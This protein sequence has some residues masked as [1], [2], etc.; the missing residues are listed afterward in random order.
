M[1]DTQDT[2]TP[3]TAEGTGAAPG[4]G[5]SGG[6]S[7]QGSTTGT[8]LSTIPTT[9]TLPPQYSTGD[10]GFFTR[11][12]ESVPTSVTVGPDSALYVGL[13]MGE[14]YPAGYAQVIRIANPDAT[15]G[16]NGTFE[17]SCLFLDPHFD[18]TA[19]GQAIM[20]QT[21]RSTLT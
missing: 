11:Q 10:L 6:T 20:A 18:P 8:S 19:L 4:G 9:T 12:M 21:A 14:P 7:L 5:G 2:S 13:L 3:A 15:T 17:H 1:S 16:H